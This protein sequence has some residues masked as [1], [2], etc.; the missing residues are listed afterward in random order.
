M[1]GRSAISES[2]VA[3]KGR[4]RRVARMP[5]RP[6]QT[7]LSM[8]GPNKATV[9]DEAAYGSARTQEAVQV[10]AACFVLLVGQGFDLL[11]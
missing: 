9:R 11:D 2:S 6:R 1:K 5:V 10:P 7:Q 3:V 8:Y 4:S